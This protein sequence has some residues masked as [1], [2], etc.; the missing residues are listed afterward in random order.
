MADQHISETQPS[1]PALGTPPSLHLLQ[2]DAEVGL[3]TDGY[4]VL[5]SAGSAAAKSA[6][7]ESA[8]AE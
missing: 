2:T 1:G 5:P 3:C 8:P 4:C 6:P 7:A